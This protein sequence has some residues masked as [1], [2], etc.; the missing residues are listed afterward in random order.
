MN[1]NAP[2]TG[3][4][5]VNPLQDKV[6]L[7]KQF[8][9]AILQ[10]KLAVDGFTELSLKDESINEMAA[11]RSP[12]K[13]KLDEVGGVD[14]LRAIVVTQCLQC[15]VVAPEKKLRHSLTGRHKDALTIVENCIDKLQGYGKYL[16]EANHVQALQDVVNFL[17]A[18]HYSLKPTLKTNQRKEIL[19]HYMRG[20]TMAHKFSHRYEH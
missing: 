20:G 8:A 16:T 12:S 5:A 3:N 2:L 13:H 18:L 10:T 7:E 14:G 19:Q 4:Y 11:T 15:V 1:E 17:F 9:T 6:S